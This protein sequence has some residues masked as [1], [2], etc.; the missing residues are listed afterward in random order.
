MSGNICSFPGCDVELAPQKSMNRL[1]GEEAHIKGEKPT[2]PRYDPHQ[3][4]V[5]RKSY[6]NRILL[7][8]THHTLIDANPDEWTAIRLV[9]MKK[10]HE[11]QV[12]QNRQFPVFVDDI[13]KVLQKY[14]VP[15]DVHT[16]A[17][18]LIGDLID[19]KIFRVD[20]SKEGGINTNILL[21]SGQ[22][23]TFFARGLISYDGSR[24][25]FTT[26]EGI[27]CNEYGIPIM[28]EDDKGNK[29][30]VVWPHPEAYKT[31]GTTLGRIGSLIGWVGD[32]SE[33]RTFLIG[34]K[35][36]MIVENDGY[37]FLMVNDAK[38]T[39]EDNNG[40]YRVEIRVLE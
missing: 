32:Y 39:Y 29:S 36:E 24:Q 11:N 40:E 2:A 25:Q 6:E 23:V 18:D 1:I 12:R 20:A 35:W 27:I 19:V 22:R 15:E 10:G 9:Q 21:K 38:G 31:N 17:T 8:P 28:E 5:E 30:M 7:C 16:P 4:E 34:S 33:Q 3:T 13:K 37:L 14:E 26:P